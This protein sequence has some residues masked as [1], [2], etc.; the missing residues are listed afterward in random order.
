MGDSVCLSRRPVAGLHFL[1][2]V[3]F[4][5]LL[6]LVKTGV[7]LEGAIVSSIIA[8]LLSAYILCTPSRLLRL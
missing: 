7:V 6:L 5:G 8:N 3:A 1:R 4:K 2:R